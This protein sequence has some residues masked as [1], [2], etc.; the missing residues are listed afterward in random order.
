[1]SPR[2]ALS[3][4]MLLA[5]VAVIVYGIWLLSHPAAFIVGGLALAAGGAFMGFDPA[6]RRRRS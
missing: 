4:C 1:M 3:D 2:S 5:G 6:A